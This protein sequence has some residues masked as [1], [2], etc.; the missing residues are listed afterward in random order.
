[1]N[2]GRVCGIQLCVLYIDGMELYDVG[3]VIRIVST[4]LMLFCR[5]DRSA[6]RQTI[7]W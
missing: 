5:A 2:L 4:V 3:A 6:R 7:G 1:M